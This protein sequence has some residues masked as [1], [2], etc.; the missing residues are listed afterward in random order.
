MTERN[1]E[2]K[3]L[4]RPENQGILDIVNVVPPAER[5]STAL[6]Y[7]KAVDD[8]LS[9]TFSTGNEWFKGMVELRGQLRKIIDQ[10]IE[11]KK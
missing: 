8:T 2:I 6:S 1:K 5:K 11:S 9:T 7:L 10:T 3:P 4:I